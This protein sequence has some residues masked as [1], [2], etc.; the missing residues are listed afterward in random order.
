M[1]SMK[2]LFAGISLFVGCLSISAQEKLMEIKAP[3]SSVKVCLNAALISHTQ[4]VK[5]RPG[6][7]KLAFVGLAMNIDNRN[8][9]LRNI[10]NGELL[11]LQLVKLSDTTDIKNLRPDLLYFIKNYKD[12]ILGIEKTIRKVT[13]ELQ[14]LQLEQDMLVKND[15]IIPN[16]KQMTLAELKTT[17]EYYRERSTDI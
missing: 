14:G 13:Y 8:I 12:S 16:G 15:N 3:I 6:I 5:L 10:G 4:K 7:T 2:K 1:N 17:T 9:S 11:S